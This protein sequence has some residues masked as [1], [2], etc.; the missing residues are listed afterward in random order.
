ME[1]YVSQ[2][3]EDLQAAKS[4]KV[5]TLVKDE[6]GKA[7]LEKYLGIEHIA[8]PPAD[9]LSESQIN[10]L[11]EAFMSLLDVHHYIVNITM[12]KNLPPH[13]LYQYF[14]KQW[15]EKVFYTTSGLLG[16]EFCDNNPEEC[17]LYEWCKGFWCECDDD[18]VPQV[19][20]GIYD[21]DGNKID[22]STIPIPAL[23]LTCRSYLVDDWEENLLCSMNRADSRKDGEEFICG[24]YKKR[25]KR[26]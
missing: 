17:G 22:V 10:A 25:K 2:L 26:D 3:I 1:R 7:T 24:T 15:T 23:C 14:V 5:S 13:I 11:N 21:D 19:Y 4:K 12:I 16:L 18:Y 9:R 20:N 8:F 6:D